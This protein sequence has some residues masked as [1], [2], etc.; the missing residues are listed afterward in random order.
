MLQEEE[1]SRRIMIETILNPFSKLLVLSILCA[2]IVTV[3]L[4]PARNSCSIRAPLVKSGYCPWS[5]IH[6]YI[7]KYSVNDLWSWQTFTRLVLFGFWNELMQS[8][9]EWQE[10]WTHIDQ[11]S[12]LVRSPPSVT[13]ANIED[14]RESGNLITSHGS[15]MN[16]DACCSDGRFIIR[17][18]FVE[19]NLTGCYCSTSVR[20]KKARIKKMIVEK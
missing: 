4:K 2:L 18:T 20:G 19:R 5:W 11:V 3:E 12:L 17:V 6:A 10:N 16:L 9:F 15:D 8:C 13:V 7:Y 1:P 14:H